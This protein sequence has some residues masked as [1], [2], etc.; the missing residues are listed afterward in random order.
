MRRG[1]GRGAAGCGSS[2]PRIKTF[3]D[4]APDSRT[5][6]YVDTH[7]TRVLAMYP[8]DSGKVTGHPHTSCFVADWDGL[9]LTMNLWGRPYSPPGVRPSHR[10]GNPFAMHNQ[11]CTQGNSIDQRAS[12]S[13]Y[14]ALLLQ[15]TLVR[16]PAQ[17][18]QFNSD[19]AEERDLTYL[20]RM[21]WLPV[22]LESF[23]SVF[24]FRCPSP[25]GALAANTCRGIL[26]NVY[27]GGT[28]HH[29]IDN[30]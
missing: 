4:Q 11:H 18:L 3:N 12:P 19:A 26:E 14:L 5:H 17:P 6:E 22:G 24:S 7:T 9:D 16:V 28:G 13:I 2:R 27:G 10:S 21:L 1:R 23:P 20:P 15:F 30:E 8:R 25:G 29:S